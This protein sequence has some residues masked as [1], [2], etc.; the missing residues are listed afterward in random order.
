MRDKRRVPH[1]HVKLRNLSDDVVSEKAFAFVLSA[2]DVPYL[3]MLLDDLIQL[4]ICTI[5]GLQEHVDYIP[6]ASSVMCSCRLF[7]NRNARVIYSSIWCHNI[8]E[9]L[10]HLKADRNIAYMESDIDD[11]QLESQYQHMRLM[12]TVPLPLWLKT[13]HTSL[14]VIT[15]KSSPPSIVPFCKRRRTKINNVM[16]SFMKELNSHREGRFINLV[17]PEH[18]NK[19]KDNK[20]YY[21]WALSVC[22]RLFLVEIGI[23]HSIHELSD[24][25]E[26]IVYPGPLLDYCMNESFR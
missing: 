2:G 9:G 6:R 7:C 4:R 23:E 12:T 19:L 10:E 21:I 26:C 25:Y 22:Q 16:I 5:A 18:R 3:G 8:S 13:S 17:S 1:C 15:N 14:Y 11:P 20:E 24:Y